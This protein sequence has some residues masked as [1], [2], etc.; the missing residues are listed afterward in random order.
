MKFWQA[1]ILRGNCS[2]DSYTPIGILQN[3]NLTEKAHH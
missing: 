1:A 3:H 2:V